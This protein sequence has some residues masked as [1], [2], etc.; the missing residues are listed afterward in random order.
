MKY[1]HV[2]A[3]MAL[4]VS[5]LFTLS[6]H[7][8][9]NIWEIEQRHDPYTEAFFSTTKPHEPEKDISTL[10]NQKIPMPPAF[11]EKYVAALILM[12]RTLKKAKKC[13]ASINAEKHPE[14][15]DRLKQIR[16]LRSLC[17]KRIT[18]LILSAID[19]RDSR[20]SA[21]ILHFLLTRK[22]TRQD[23]KWAITGLKH[24]EFENIGNNFHQT[25]MEYITQINRAYEQYKKEK[26]ATK[27]TIEKNAP[28]EQYRMGDKK[29]GSSQSCRD[30]SKASN[31]NLPFPIDDL[32]V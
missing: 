17:K 29:K 20:I 7:A 1:Q 22:P 13:S 8:A 30:L 4:C 19:P 28:K 2:V 5:T 15:I 24:T 21:N 6:S 23:E 10:I 14:L 12:N 25:D 27:N 31:N 11:I 32:P 26:H 18:P 3:A 16:T 9:M